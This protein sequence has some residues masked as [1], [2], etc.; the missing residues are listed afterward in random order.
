MGR[1]IVLLIATLCVWGSVAFVLVS[2]PSPD[3]FVYLIMGVAAFLST[4]IIWGIGGSIDMGQ[5]HAP[6]PQWQER[7]YGETKAKRTASGGSLASVVDGMTPEQMAALEI[8]LQR[9]RETFDEDDQILVNRLSAELE[10]SVK[11]Q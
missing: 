5:K 1:L 3:T 7:E 6:A 8:A 2:T 9:R 10:R 4:G 11:S